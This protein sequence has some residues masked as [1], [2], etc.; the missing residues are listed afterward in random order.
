MP[1]SGP[2]APFT[3]A[4]NLGARIQ[5][6]LRSGA[7]CILNAFQ[8]RSNTKQTTKDTHIHFKPRWKPAFN[9]AVIAVLAIVVLFGISST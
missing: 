7:H 3:V 1:V 8:S 2:P 5:F 6:Y 9:E 4:K